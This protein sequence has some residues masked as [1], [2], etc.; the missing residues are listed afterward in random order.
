[1]SDRTY[2]SRRDGIVDALVL[3]LKDIDGT[4]SWLS[5]LNDQVWHSLKFWDEIQ[6]FPAVHLNAGA[7]SRVYQGG[8]YKDRF[9]NIT[10][11]CYVKD[12]VASIQSLNKILEDVET[13]IETNSRLAY[14]D[15]QGTTQYTQQI[16]I[17]SI[18]TD[19]GALD[20]IGIGEIVVE[21][22]Y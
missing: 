12:D 20:P 18:E 19:E 21:V 17:V 15:K 11:R 6:E 7:E 8:G 14:T 22:Q 13:L 10:I 5:N 2:T 3:K 1:M 16:T 4:G 9:L